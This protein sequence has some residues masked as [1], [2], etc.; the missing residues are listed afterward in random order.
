MAYAP[1]NKR[2]LYVGGLSDNVDEKILSAAFIPFGDIVTCNIPKN[3][4][5]EEHRGFGF[6]EYED[7][8]DAAE[9]VDNMNDSEMYGRTIRVTIARPQQI[10]EGWGRAIWSDDAWLKKYA[11]GGQ[12]MNEDGELM[13][14]TDNPEDS[15]YTSNV[16]RDLSAAD[17]QARLLDRDVDVQMQ[18][19]VG[20]GSSYIRPGEEPPAV[21]EVKIKQKNPR[22]FFDCKI[23]AHFAGRVTMELR[24]DI[25]PRTCENFRQLCIMKKGFGYR[26]SK[27]HRIIPEFMLQGGDFTN[28]NGTGGKSVYG[29]KFDDENFLLKHDA[30]GTLSMANSGPN[31]NGSQFFITTVA[32]PWLDNKHVVFGYVI[33][34][35][36]VVRKIENQGTKGGRPRQTIQIVDSGE[37]DY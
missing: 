22:V 1:T 4:E 23:G 25:V 6:I 13:Q 36:E 28:G 2:V 17:A 29:M 14:D 15:I 24:A 19:K 27:F 31:T 7:K 30:P 18:E 20:P 37:V 11:G 10:K 9:A 32:T 5:T 8:E 21:T 12:E 34:G 33:S 35:M 3:Y 16:A 26:N